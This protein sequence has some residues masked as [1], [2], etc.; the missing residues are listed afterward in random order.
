[1]S[2]NPRSKKDPS[3]T[4]KQLRILT[5]I[6]DSRREHG[7]APTMQELADEFQVSKVTVFE[8]VSA[9]EKKGYLRRS[10]HKARSL[11]LNDGIPFPDERS[12]ILPLA[13]TIA[14]GYP[15]EAVEDSESVDLEELFTSPNGNFV[16]KV[17]GDSMIEDCICDGDYVVVEKRSNARNGETVVALLDDGEATLKRFYKEKG[18][19]RLQPANEAYEP[20][21]VDRVDIQGVVV[22]VLRRM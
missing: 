1:M 8:H 19:Y 3:I 17:R 20:I 2:R 9:L 6:R 5:Y 11:Q 15:I 18:K 14:A 12:T 21:I 22:G 13:G 4:P 7:F 16:L 10:P